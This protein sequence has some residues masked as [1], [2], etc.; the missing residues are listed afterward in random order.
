MTVVPSKM[1]SLVFLICKG[2]LIVKLN[3]IMFLLSLLYCI[4]INEN[5]TVNMSVGDI[6]ENVTDLII[7]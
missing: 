1:I 3:D 5:N 4:Y 2:D 6:G 7:I